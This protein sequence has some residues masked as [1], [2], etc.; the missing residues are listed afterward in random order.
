MKKLIYTLCFFVLACSCTDYAN[1]QKDFIHFQDSILKLNSDSIAELK[2]LVILEVDQYRDSAI[3]QVDTMRANFLLFRDHWLSVLDS[4]K[5]SK[6]YGNMIIK[7]DTIR[8]FEA[9]FD[10]VTGKPYLIMR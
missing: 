2:R 1:K 9:R 7:S 5:D 6:I 4:M 10:S 3:Y 8:P